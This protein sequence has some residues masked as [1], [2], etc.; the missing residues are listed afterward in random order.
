MGR[1]GAALLLLLI[2]V[3]FA[4]RGRPQWPPGEN[5][6]PIQIPIPPNPLEQEKKRR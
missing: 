5:P 4:K 2:A 3:A 6:L 1:D